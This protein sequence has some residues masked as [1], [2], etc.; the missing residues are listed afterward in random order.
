MTDRKMISDP[1][2]LKALSH[3]LR[4]KLIDVLTINGSATA[5][6]CAEAVGESVASCSYH[7]N[8]LAKYGFVQQAEGGQGREKPW[9]LIDREQSYTHDGLNEEDTLAAEAATEALLE[10]EFQRMRGYLRTHDRE[11]D[12]W[13]GFGGFTGMTQHLTA[14]EASR[15]REDIEALFQRYSGRNEMENRPS[16]SRPVRFQLMS[17]AIPGTEETP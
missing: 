10:H 9:R 17:Y 13:R 4:W 12:A 5:T 16:G 6:Q 15:L 2:R 1:K 3:P 8:M 11:P 7:L 14:A